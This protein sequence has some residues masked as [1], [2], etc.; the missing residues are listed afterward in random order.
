MY[1]CFIDESGTPPKPSAKNPRP[2]FVIGG[3]IIH[4]S[5]W[6]EIAKELRQ[7]RHREGFQVFGEIKWRYF[8]GQNDDPDNT[9]TR[10]SQEKRDRFRQ[11][12]FQILTKRKSVKIICCV[13]NVSLAY[14]QKYVRDEEDLYFHTYKPVSE[15]FL[16][17]LQ[18]ITKLSGSRQLGIIVADHRGKKQNDVLRS[19]HHRLVEDNN[20]FTST[21][22]H[23]V[24]TIFLTP[25]H[26]SVGIQFADMVAGAVSR[27]F[28]SGD[29]TFFKMIRPAIRAS[30][31]GDIQGHG[32]VKFPAGWKWEPPGGS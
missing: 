25:S 3:I 24:E 11:L 21:Y 23:Y 18:D 9:F 26:L 29:W 14:Q 22:G 30:A 19:G 8:G 5:Q 10:L 4:E 2:Y 6:H 27:G 17:Y 1:F 13:T 16:Y 32:V 12:M 7:L 28:N 20:A 31:T 15:R